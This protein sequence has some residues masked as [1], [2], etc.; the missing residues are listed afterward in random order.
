MSKKLQALLLGALVTLN[1]GLAIILVTLAGS[2]IYPVRADA[3]QPVE[4]AVEEN[5]KYQPL[6]DA[7]QQ[8]NISQ[9]QFVPLQ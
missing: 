8:R 5:V 2:E 9:Q 7:P 6:L 4:I 3:A 1:L